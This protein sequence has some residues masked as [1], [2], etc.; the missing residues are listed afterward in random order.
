MAVFN[1]TGKGGSVGGIDTSDATAYAENIEDAYTAYARGSKITGTKVPIDVNRRL[2][3]HAEDLTDSGPF[4]VPLSGTA[5]ISG[6]QAKFGSNSIYFSGSTYLDA[7]KLSI[8][9]FDDEL[10]TLDMWIYFTAYSS[11]SRYC[12]AGKYSADPYSWVFEILSGRINMEFRQ[13][14]STAVVGIAS[15][16]QSFASNT[17]YHLCLQRVSTA[18]G[19]NSFRMYLNGVRIL[20]DSSW[21][22]LHSPPADVILTYGFVRPGIEFG[23]MQSAGRYFT[24]YMDEIHLNIGSNTFDVDGFTPPIQ[25][26][27]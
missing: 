16:A 18:A 10:F 15:A 14:T 1:M 17:W 19:Y 20:Y 27:T 24:G 7:N 9:S 2:L 5:V 21:G 3:L 26:Y 22:Y 6:S 23:R 4:N 12:L 13:S 25:P 8:F 11:S